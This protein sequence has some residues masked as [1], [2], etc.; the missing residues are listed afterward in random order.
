MSV[1]PIRGASVVPVECSLQLMLYV[2]YIKIKNFSF[3]KN[4]GYDPVLS[5]ICTL[6]VSKCCFVECML[7]EGRHAV[8]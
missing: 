7:S 5:Y 3:L 8:K 2:R 6:I 4:P 1:G